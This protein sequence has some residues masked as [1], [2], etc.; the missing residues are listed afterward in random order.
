M[1]QCQ[2]KTNHSGRRPMT[3]VAGLGVL[4]ALAAILLPAAPAAAQESAAAPGVPVGLVLALGN[5]KL[6]AGWNPPEGDGGAEITAYTVEYKT[7]TAP[8]RAGVFDD[9]NNGWLDAG[10]GGTGTDA[11]ITGLTNGVDYDVRVRASNSEGDSQWSATASA[12][13]HEDVIWSAIL[14]VDNDYGDGTGDFG[15]VIDV[16]NSSIDDCSVALTD[17]EFAFGL[18]DYGWTQFNRSVLPG[19]TPRYTTVGLS[20]LVP[21]DSNLRKGRIQVG[22]ELV[23][24]DDTVRVQWFVPDP[25]TFRN[26]QWIYAGFLLHDDPSK[27]MIFWTEGQRVPLSLQARLPQVHVTDETPAGLSGSIADATL[28]ALTVSDGTNDV[29]LTPAFASATAGYTASV[30]NSVDSV[31]VTPTANDPSAT[32]TVEGSEVTSGTASSSI[33][34]VAG[35]PKAISVVV[36][37]PDGTSKTYTVTVTRAM[38]SDATLSALAVSDGTNDMS[39][40]PEFTAT[41]TG[42]TTSV[43]NSVDSVTVTPTV[44]DE[45]ATVTVE[46]SAVTSGKASPALSLTA[47][48]DKDIDV[49]VT[50]QNGTSKTYT[51]TVTRA[52]SS[53]ATLSALAVSDGTN[54]V[55]LT[56]A[57]ASATAGYTASVDNSVDSVTVTPT[58][59]DPSAT[60]TVEGSEVT[61]GTASSSIALVAGSPKA[62]SV[63]VTTPDG[64]SKTYTVTVTRAMSSDATLSALAVS[65]GTNDMSL[66]PEFTATTTGYTASVDNS[67]DSVT[68]TPTV[69]D[70]NATVTVEGSAVTSGKASP[71]LSLTAGVDK[72]IDIV[73]T[74][75]DGTTNTYTVTVTR[76]AAVYEAPV[77]LALE[78][79]AP[80]LTLESLTVS[81]GTNDVPLT[82][83]FA[84][85]TADYTASVGNSVGSV[86]VT[87]TVNDPDTTVTVGGSRVTSG[88]PSPPIALT[89][90][91]AEIID[92]VLTHGSFTNTYT[93]AVTR[94]N[95]F[96]AS[97][98]A[99]GSDDDGLLEMCLG[100]YPGNTEGLR[101]CE[102]PY[103]GGEAVLMLTL[104]GPAP[105]N[106][107]VV[108]L[109]TGDQSATSDD[110]TMPSSI[111]IGEGET[112]GLITIAII[113]DGIDEDDESIHIYVCIRPGCD[114]LNLEAGE[115]AYNHGI[116]IP[117]TRR[118][119]L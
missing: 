110:Y 40:T 53:D 2:T 92:I 54:D 36:T 97:K 35:S 73:V 68:V 28:S 76:E 100:R 71:A 74:A 11:E 7:T 72:D 61:S 51:V 43:D 32:V 98:Q 41:T 90:G 96:T 116:T 34:L 37:T 95:D 106:G 114:P 75:Q 13:P 9:P 22:A 89:A 15:C 16:L 26:M 62:I 55:P 93:V 103:E 94:A 10:H 67:V 105:A 83:V 80:D 87:P 69:N 58:A 23:S 91:D 111:T 109:A 84:L 48:V 12:T 33:A 44:N 63:V 66:T 99:Q 60:V 31:T 115:K 27:G 30:D 52:M 45:N 19:E 4:I 88:T 118:G 79:R 29:P 112:H 64:T 108:T 86:T 14:T 65:D 39:L 8:N 46:G 119:G 20:A 117:G 50:A 104:P 85:D 47:G 49:V 101:V 82:P 17:D 42:Y 21:D 57:F 56:P 59:N 1:E 70:E 5:G 107:T 18:D 3:L 38:S 6:V 113:A 81:D 24:L 102:T 25:D 78:S 77:V